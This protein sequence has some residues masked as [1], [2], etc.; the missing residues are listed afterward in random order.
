MVKWCVIGAGGIADRRAIPAL[1]KDK[2]NCLVAIME[3]VPEL[4]EELGRKYG[5]PFFTDERE[6]LSSVECDAVY[7]GTPVACHKAQAETVLEFGKH[8]FVEKPMGI[9]GD[10]CAEL[11]EKYK[12]KSLQL[13]VGYMMGY[14]NLH[15][16]AKELIRSGG[17][18]K[19]NDLR[20]QFGCY[21]PK[22]EGAWRQNRSLSGGGVIMDL[23]VHCIELCEYLLDEEI[24]DVKS[25]YS[26]RAFNY[27]VEDSG[28]VI[29]RTE[30]G[31]LGHIDVNFNLPDATESKVEI[32]G[33]EGYII[34]KGTLAQ[35]EVGT[36]SYLYSPQGGYDAAQSA[37]ESEPQIFAAEG[38]DIYLRQIRDFCR[39][40]E[41]GAPEYD[42]TERAVRVQRTID[43][44]YADGR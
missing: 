36:L 4:A 31:I 9:N 18:G 32:Y 35:E 15:V 44:I 43:K 10:E 42:K 28:I 26:T 30:S 14:H 37:V 39:M 6:M 12:A 19:V 7:I 23:G 17:V 2:N 16:K 5:V 25:F 3:R 22:I 33:T 8:L 21:Y 1:L 29:F 38:E 13:T 11:L 34:A 27:E 41:S 40:V 20:V 24:V